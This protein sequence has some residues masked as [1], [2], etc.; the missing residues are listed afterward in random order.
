ME[1]YR[2]KPTPQKPE[3]NNAGDTPEEE[4]EEEDLDQDPLAE[5][6]QPLQ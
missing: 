5:G 4:G 3:P 6:S 1:E 2:K